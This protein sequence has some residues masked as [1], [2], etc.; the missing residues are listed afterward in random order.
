M[1]KEIQKRMDAVAKERDRID[2]LMSEMRSLRDDCDEAWDSLM[3][4]RD[5]LSRLV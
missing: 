2:E 1:L 3:D 4:A 5:A